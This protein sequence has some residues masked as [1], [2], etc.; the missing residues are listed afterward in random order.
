MKKSSAMNWK[1][2]IEHAIRN[3]KL[4]NGKPDSSSSKLK[5]INVIRMSNFLILEKEVGNIM[6][7][8]QD[9]CVV[10]RIIVNTYSSVNV[11]F[12]STFNQMGIFWDWV[13]PIYSTI[14][15]FCWSKNKILRQNKFAHFGLK[16]N[17]NG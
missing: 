4:K 9:H 10:K 3:A 13:L 14:S 1:K 15:G 11:L 6:E 12:E 17:I 8:I 7:M 16:H 2:A 5:V